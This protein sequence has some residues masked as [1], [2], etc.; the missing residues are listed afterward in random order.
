M[1]KVK[2]KVLEIDYME[3]NKCCTSKLSPKFSC[4]WAS[5]ATVTYS[6]TGSIKKIV[7][8]CFGAKQLR[9]NDQ[10]SSGI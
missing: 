9:K 1:S 3:M 7:F 4:S 5:I 2:K 8:Q 10:I 6:I